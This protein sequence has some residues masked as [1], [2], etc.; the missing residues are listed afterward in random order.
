MAARS[1]VQDAEAPRRTQCVMRAAFV[2]R[3]KPITAASTRERTA[4]TLLEGCMGIT[5]PSTNPNSTPLQ[6]VRP[7][8]SPACASCGPTS[9]HAAGLSPGVRLWSAC[10]CEIPGFSSSSGCCCDSSLPYLPFVFSHLRI[11]P[12]ARRIRRHTT[13]IAHATHIRAPEHTK[14]AGRFQRLFSRPP[15]AKPLSKAHPQELASFRTIAPACGDAGR[16]LC[17]V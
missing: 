9:G 14:P 4:T 3:K 1:P 16:R 13:P 2:S 5:P 17:D 7:Y 8:G 12:H 15:A 10:G 11:A 6:R